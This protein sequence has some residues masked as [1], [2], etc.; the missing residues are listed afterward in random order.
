MISKNVRNCTNF[1]YI[2]VTRFY[3][4]LDNCSSDQIN[5]FT[6]VATNFFQQ[7]V[8]SKSSKNSKVFSEINGNI[9]YEKEKIYAFIY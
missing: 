3:I 4:T 1:E 9:E 8:F 5:S 7:R 6:I 2:F